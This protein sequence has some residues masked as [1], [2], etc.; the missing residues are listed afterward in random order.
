VADWAALVDVFI[1]ELYAWNNWHFDRKAS[2]GRAP[3]LSLSSG[4]PRC[5][6]AVYPSWCLHVTHALEDF[7]SLEDATEH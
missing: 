7:K 1:L 5:P 2:L 4:L 3:L 6:D